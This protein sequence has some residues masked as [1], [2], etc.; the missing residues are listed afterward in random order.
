MCAAGLGF[1]SVGS[2]DVELVPEVVRQKGI[3]KIMSQARTAKWVHG[4]ELCMRRTLALCKYY[5][6]TW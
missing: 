2:G 5:D 4:L 3:N 1:A 6:T